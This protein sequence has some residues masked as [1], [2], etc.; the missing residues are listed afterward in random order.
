LSVCQRKLQ[1]NALFYQ[2]RVII[3]I[4]KEQAIDEMKRE[5]ELCIQNMKKSSTV[6][7]C[8]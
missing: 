2:R 6:L 1:K 7:G 5:K 4:K 8:C 3:E